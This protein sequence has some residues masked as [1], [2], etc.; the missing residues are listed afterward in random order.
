MEK[1]KSETMRIGKA[2]L[3]KIKKM[4]VRKSKHVGR[5]VTAAEIVED[6]LELDLNR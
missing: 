2:A 1:T 5:D 3:D 4:A 6:L